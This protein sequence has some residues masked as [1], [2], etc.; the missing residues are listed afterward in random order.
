M[1]RAPRLESNRRP[2]GDRELATAASRSTPLTIVSGAVAGDDL[3][4]VARAASEGIG[5]PV[6]IALPAIGGT[7]VFPP[8]AIE[9]SGMRE[10]VDYAVAIIRGESGEKPAV[11]AYAVPIRIGLDAVGIVATA[12]VQNGSAR[13]P[14]SEEPRGWLE[15][16]ATAAAVTALMREARAGNE[17]ESRR[18]LLRA[19]SIGPRADVTA[20]VG[21]AR[22]LGFDLSQGAAAICGRP[23][24]GADRE[25]A[26]DSSE[27]PGVLLA[28]LGGGRVV[29][30]V[31]A[32][33]EA[34]GERTAAIA[35]E[36]EARGMRVAVSSR[37]RDPGTLHDAVREAE[38][39]LELSALAGA[40]LS[41]QEETYRLL[42]GVLL[43]DPEELGSLR[44][45]TISPLA[46]YDA[47][48]DTELLATLETFL[49]HDGSTT[50]TAEAMNLHRHTVGYR[51]TRVQEVSQLS[52]YESEGRERLSLGLKADQ[53]LEA[54]KRRAH[55]C[56]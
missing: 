54:A 25:H 38:L 15:A 23:L 20:L 2:D 9:P 29:G 11:I 5:Q 52:P 14:G 40:S 39:L 30:L 47:K 41:G 50:E 17:Q 44:A 43:R 19:L 7:I 46:T 8:E 18:A 56:S 42:I 3:E 36:L 33:S 53:I 16:A 49:A 35:S 22:T 51:L 26:P 45:G 34:A 21:H 48:N 6:V 31:P 24:P 28:D 12:N 55:G 37:R 1:R 27:I 32:S 13:E 4:R 10:I